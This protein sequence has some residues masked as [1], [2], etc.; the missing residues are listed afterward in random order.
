MGQTNR[1][2]PKTHPTTPHEPEASHSQAIGLT[3]SHSLGSH[4]LGEKRALALPREV[5]YWS[6]TN[7]REKLVEIGTKV[8]CHGRSVT[9][10][11]AEVAVPRRP[12][13]AIVQ[14]IDGLWPRPAPT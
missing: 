6:L 12:F 8:V 9:F 11:L 1:Q 7:L 13:A 3:F 2:I 5:P 10:R 14:L 4:S